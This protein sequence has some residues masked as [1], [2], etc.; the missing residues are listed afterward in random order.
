MAQVAEHL[1]HRCE[2]LCSNP[3]IALPK[4]NLSLTGEVKQKDMIVLHQ[5]KLWGLGHRLF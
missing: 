3:S 1:P 4:V 5:F 2:A